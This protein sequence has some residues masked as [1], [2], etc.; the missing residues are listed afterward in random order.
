LP[1]FKPLYI[2]NFDDHGTPNLP[3]DVDPHNPFDLFSLF[4]TDDIIDKLVE[5]TNKHVELYPLD[6]DKENPRPWEL[7][8]KKELYAYLAVLI[9]MGITTEPAIEDY[10]KDLKTYG[11][12]HV[13]KQYISV[14]RFQQLDR[15]FRAS[16]PWPKSDKTPRSIFNRVDKLA[17]HLRLTCRK[18]YTPRTYL[19]YGP[20]SSALYI[21]KVCILQ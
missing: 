13:I 11:T 19:P 21:K 1:E 6:E 10:W 17:E 3:P 2:N 7:I 8:Y 16:P 15:Y 12:L 4:F 20:L 9:H 18:L 5:W 14:V